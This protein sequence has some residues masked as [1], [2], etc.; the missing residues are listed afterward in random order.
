MSDLFAGGHQLPHRQGFEGSLQEVAVQAN[1]PSLSS[2]NEC[3]G[4]SG[5]G[6][7]GRR[8]LVEEEVIRFE[9]F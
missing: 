5:K 8:E 2:R 1:T 6:E 3:S 9:A 7:F 4:E